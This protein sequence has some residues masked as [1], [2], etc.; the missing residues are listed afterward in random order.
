MLQLLKLGLVGL[1][2]TGVAACAHV[3]AAQPAPKSPLDVPAP[4]PHVVVPP[5]DPA[6]PP[7]PP[8]TP[9]PEAQSRPS[10]ASAP[11]RPPDKPPASPPA[12]PPPAA[13][14][15]TPPLE[16]TSDVSALEQQTRALIASAKRDLAKVEPSSLS[17]DTRAQYLR[18]Q[19]FVKQAESAMQEKNL[20]YARNMAEKAAALASQLPKTKLEGSH[21]SMPHFVLTSN[22]S[23]IKR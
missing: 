2:L 22:H 23:P 17:S 1:A 20:T 16:M 21:R 9:A 3:Q 13:E 14:V 10:S 4:P 11:V 8:T 5:G 12:T 7:P 19:G 15:A 6:P 18:A